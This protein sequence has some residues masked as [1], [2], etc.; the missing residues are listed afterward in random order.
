MTAD[1]ILCKFHAFQ[2]WKKV[3]WSIVD[4]DLDKLLIFLILIWTTVSLRFPKVEIRVSLVQH[5][6]KCV[7]AGHL[8]AVLS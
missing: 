1:I 6:A 4:Q 7:S 8:R 5:L 2:K 3:F